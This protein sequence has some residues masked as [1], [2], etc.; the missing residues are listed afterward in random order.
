MG[1]ELGAG[2]ILSAKRASFIGVGLQGERG[3]GGGGRGGGRVGMNWVLATFSQPREP[4]S[5][6]WGYK[7]RRERVGEGGEEGGEWRGE[8]GQ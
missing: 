5:S 6:E 4:L 8:G 1:N 3:K 2:N 7:V